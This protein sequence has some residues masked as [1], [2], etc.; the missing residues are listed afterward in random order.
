MKKTALVSAACVIGLAML[1]AS[2][3]AAPTYTAL[4]AKGS[5][6]ID[7]KIDDSWKSAT[8]IGLNVDDAT[9]SE[10]GHVWGA[11]EASCKFMLMW[12]NKYSYWAFDVTDADI[13][14]DAEDA[15]FWQ[16]DCVSGFMFCG[17]KDVN[18][19]FFTAPKDDAYTMV[20]KLGGGAEVNDE[21]LTGYVL[22]KTG[23]TV[24]VAIPWSIVN[25]GV[26]NAGD[27][28]SFTTLLID[29]SAEWGQVM[30]VG[31]GDNS[32]NFAFVKF[33]E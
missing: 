22:T 3:L 27:V 11:V 2:A 19:K 13:N 29:Q 25:D 28:Y 12:D 20:G 8:P 10:F 32:D 24:E 1:S 26:P 33:S 14:V 16:R 18:M 15:S 5:V 31:D 7:G 6:K 17:D 21:V 23:Y 30:W 4:K 9:V